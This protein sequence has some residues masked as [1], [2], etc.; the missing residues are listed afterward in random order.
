MNLQSDQ[1]RELESI[2][3]TH[4]GLLKPEDVVDFAKNPQTALHSA[5]VWD[6]TEAAAKYRLD[7]A[8]QVIRLVVTIIGDSPEP[9]RAFVSIPSDRVSGGGYRSM[10]D[11][12]SDSSRRAEMLR[13]A[14]ERLLSVKR[15]YAHLQALQ[16][17]YD[18]IDAAVAAQQSTEAPASATG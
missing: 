18:A 8:R 13:E 17:V 4:G 10:A 5:F 9:V 12:V 3:A 7:Q 15:K 11:V 16:P 14:L 1:A 6:D 2:R